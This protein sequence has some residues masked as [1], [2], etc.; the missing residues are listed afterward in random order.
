LGHSKGFAA[1]QREVARREQESEH[2]RIFQPIVIPGLLQIPPYAKRVMELSNV[3]NQPDIRKAIEARLARQAILYEPGRKFEFLITESALLSRFCAAETMIRQLDW[4]SSLLQV[5]QL[6]IG[7]ISNT[8]AL[9]N[10]PQNSFFLY[11]D[12][13]VVIETYSGAITVSDKR[14]IENFGHIFGQMNSAAIFGSQAEEFLD[15][16]KKFLRNCIQDNQAPQGVH[17]QIG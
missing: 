2:I 15:R 10:I 9:P 8:A 7:L 4:L 14:D 12:D 5:K 1:R 11:D 3:T 13:F 16:C 17:D 6:T